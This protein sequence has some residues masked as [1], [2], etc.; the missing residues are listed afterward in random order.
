M[1]ETDAQLQSLLPQRAFG[2]F[3]LLCDFGDWRSCLRMSSQ[4]REQGLSPTLTLRYLVVSSTDAGW[5]YSVF[6]VARS[7]RA[8]AS[9]YPP[10]GGGWGLNRKTGIHRISKLFGPRY[11]RV[12]RM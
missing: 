2:S 10:N 5:C 4:L 1:P 11:R 3:H 6:G 7:D 8:F 12:L 9:L